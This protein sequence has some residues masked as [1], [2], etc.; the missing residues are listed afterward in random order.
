MNL[1][2]LRPILAPLFGVA[3][4][5]AVSPR[6]GAAVNNTPI[7]ARFVATALSLSGDAGAPL[8]ILI[9]HWSSDED[10]QNLRTA[11]VENGSGKLSPV[12]RQARPEAGVMLVPGVGG[13][14]G[15]RARQRRT[16]PFQFARA[17]DTPSGRQV[18]V[19][20]DHY[21]GF[22]EAPATRGVAVPTDQQPGS[23]YSTAIAPSSEEPRFALLDIRFGPDGK[24]V[25]K[26][27]TAAKVAY[28]PAKK[29][30]EIENFTAQPVRL[31]EVKS[32]TP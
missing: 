7:S 18:I 20:T 4:C 17:I 2:S 14:L 28:N 6:P 31:S 32:T 15:D 29:I 9:T 10:L 8:E 5:F 25:G 24:G 27:A 3:I 1:V 26:I 13:G 12:F 21:L 23:G 19:A 11:L 30:V 16:L 22:G